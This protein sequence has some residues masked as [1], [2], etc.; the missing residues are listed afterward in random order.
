M[1]PAFDLRGKRI[2]VAGHGGMVGSALVRALGNVD[3]DILTAS[4]R[5]LDLRRQD[6]VEVWMAKMRPDAIFLA[7]ATVGGI[8][9]N[10]ARPAEFL[11]NNLMIEGN[12]VEAARRN[13]VA[14][15][16]LL[17][18]SCIYPRDAAQPLTE[19]ALLTG[20]LEP[21]NEWYALAKIAGIKLCQAYRKQYGCDFISVMPTN[22]YGE[23][24]NFDPEHSHVIPGLIRKM[25]DAKKAGA[26]EI[27]AWGSGKPLREF[28][29]V[30]DMASACV[31]LMQTYSGEGHL[32]IGT[33]SDVTIRELTELVKKVVGFEGAIRF[34][35]S[36]PDGTPRKLLDVSRLHALGWRHAI[37]LEPGLAR[38][39]DWFRA[40]YDTARL[41]VAVG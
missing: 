1:S 36:R 23:G 17:G 27:L 3:C 34:D 11:Y 37:E 5:E 38:T 15:L 25:H 9:S 40:H 20:P 35:A 8:A 32:N 26:T 31:F 14:K 16:M 21:T 19:D 22:L 6:A 10:N 13:G 30:D 12:V 2:W 7:A 18:S 39:Y 33:G 4:S 41:S 24:D 28:L 29:H